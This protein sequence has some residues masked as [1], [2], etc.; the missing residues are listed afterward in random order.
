MFGLLFNW[1]L[2]ELL[3]LHSVLVDIVGDLLKVLR[4]VVKL[5]VLKVYWLRQLLYLCIINNLDVLIIIVLLRFLLLVVEVNFLELRG[6]YPLLV[7]ICDLKPHVLIS[8]VLI[9][10]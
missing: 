7:T 5:N 3:L 10:L 2:V 6:L 9:C 1:L 4:G 8:V